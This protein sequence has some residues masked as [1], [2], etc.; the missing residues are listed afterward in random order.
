MVQFWDLH[1]MQLLAALLFSSVGVLLFALAFV[2]MRR[3][4]HFNIDKELAEDQ[5]IALGIVL[6]SMMIGIS[7]IISA[8][9][10]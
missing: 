1:G 9:I 8:A 6:A 10:H 2:V 7:I 4:L 3:V 5:N